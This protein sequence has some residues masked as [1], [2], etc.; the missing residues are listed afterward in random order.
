M[1]TILLTIGV[2]IAIVLLA[3]GST[4]QSTSTIYGYVSYGGVPTNGVT[5]TLAGEHSAQ[6]VTADK[7]GHPGYYDFTVVSGANYVVSAAYRNGTAMHGYVVSAPEV[8]ID[9]DIPLPTPTPLP[10]L[11]VTPR[12]SHEPGGMVVRNDSSSFIPMSTNGITITPVPKPSRMPT[13]PPTITPIPATPT[14][15]AVPGI[16]SNVYVWLV[17]A[18]VAILAIAAAALLFLRK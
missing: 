17:I 9:L 5:V 2:I 11:T 15:T 7:D 12:P 18:L 10:S 1:R 14:P 16:L 6:T 13:A 8:R 3:A 4:A